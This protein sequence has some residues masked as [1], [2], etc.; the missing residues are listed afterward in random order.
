MGGRGSR[1][2][3]RGGWHG[4]DSRPGLEEAQFGGSIALPMLFKSPLPQ[5]H[6][7]KHHRFALRTGVK[8]SRVRGQHGVQDG[9]L[10]RAGERVPI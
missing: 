8:H 1:R 10:G 7:L 2:S 5:L 6:V 4:E 3:R 9:F